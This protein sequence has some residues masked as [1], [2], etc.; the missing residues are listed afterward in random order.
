MNNHEGDETAVTGQS[1]PPAVRSRFRTWLLAGI[2]VFAI[3]L[4]VVAAGVTLVVLLEARDTSPVKPS[5]SPHDSFL[6]LATDTT[7]VPGGE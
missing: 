1:P 4:S 3:M 2:G 6:H 7:A 5:V